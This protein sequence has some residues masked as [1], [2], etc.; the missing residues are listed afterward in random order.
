M[1]C[2]KYKMPVDSGLLNAVLLQKYPNVWKYV[3]LTEPI[4]LNCSLQQAYMR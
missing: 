1:N 4:N 2:I 3:Y